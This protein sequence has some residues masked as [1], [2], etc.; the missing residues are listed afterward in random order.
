MMATLESIIA[1]IQTDVG[2]VTGIKKAP[3]LPPENIPTDLFPFV[4]A[5]PDSGAITFH[6]NTDT[7]CLA[8]VVVEL[9]VTRKDLPLDLDKLYPYFESIPEAI[10]DDPTLNGNADTVGSISWQFGQLNWGDTETLGIRF[11]IEDLKYKIALS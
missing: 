4:I 9:H 5:Y 3:A 2:A 1:R 10:M 7:I 11:T 6:T 8:R